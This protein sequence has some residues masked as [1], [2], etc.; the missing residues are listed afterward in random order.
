M[1]F[2][3]TS[4]VVGA[5]VPDF[6]SPTYTLTAD[7]GAPNGHSEQ[8]AVTAK[9]GTQGAQV[10]LHSASSPFT[11]TMERPAQFKQLG[12]A[13]PSTGVISSVPR[14]TY[15]IRLRKG[16]TVGTFNPKV[17]ALIDCKFAIP[18][19]ADLTDTDNLRAMVSC[20]IGVLSENSDDIVET[21]ETGIL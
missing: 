7:S 6:T 13:N 17:T 3:P 12:A 5:S 14:N 18:A 19:G 20:F 4:P 11:V 15:T 2:D 1:P 9:G 16:V 10:T 21:L 8:Y